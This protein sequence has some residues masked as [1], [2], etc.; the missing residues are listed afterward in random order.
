MGFEK[1][2]KNHFLVSRDQ[3]FLLG[4]I[5]NLGPSIL[6]F[7]KVNFNAK[8]FEAK[9]KTDWKRCKKN[10]KLQNILTFEKLKAILSPLTNIQM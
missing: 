4:Y 6:H 8:D 5:A 2:P 3:H 10:D 1:Q 9:P 7:K